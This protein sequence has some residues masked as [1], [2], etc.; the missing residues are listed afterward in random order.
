MADDVFEDVGTIGK[1]GKK[2]GRKRDYLYMLGNVLVK[3]AESTFAG[4]LNIMDGQSLELSERIEN[5]AKTLGKST[6]LGK[7]LMSVVDAKNRA[8]KQAEIRED[9]T[10]RAKV[11]EQLG[12][13]AP[14]GTTP[15]NEH[16]A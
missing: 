13:K 11:R 1:K 9:E 8:K 5:L 6:F 12:V 10:I 16:S 3:T 7:L 4:A 2:R 15:V 14:I